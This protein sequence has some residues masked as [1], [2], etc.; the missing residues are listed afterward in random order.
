MKHISFILLIVIILCE[1]CTSAPDDWASDELLQVDAFGG[2]GMAVESELDTQLRIDDGIAQKIVEAKS[3]ASRI[4]KI[5]M[6]SATRFTSYE[7]GGTY[8]KGFQLSDSFEFEEEQYISMIHTYNIEQDLDDL[9]NTIVKCKSS[10]TMP[11]T[12]KTFMLIYDPADIDAYIDQ[13]KKQF[14]DPEFLFHGAKRTT[15]FSI[16]HSESRNGVICEYGKTHEITIG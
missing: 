9:K 5:D 10:I 1:I 14:D 8:T 15:G 12:S 7:N 3:D 16:P 11:S 4:K 13:I 2:E 6:K